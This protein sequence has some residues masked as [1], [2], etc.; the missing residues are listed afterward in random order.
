MVTRDRADGLKDITGEEKKGGNDRLAA[1][2]MDSR[3][4]F[5]L[6]DHLQIA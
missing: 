2:G 4:F 3:G 5:L 1:Q 6:S